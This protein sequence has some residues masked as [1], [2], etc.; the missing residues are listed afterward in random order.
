MM[1]P[2]KVGWR[3][4]A[5]VAV[6]ASF[7]PIAR[8]A[9]GLSSDHRLIMEEIVNGQAIDDALYCGPDD[10]PC[11]QAAQ[12]RFGQEPTASMRRP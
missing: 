11:W 9:P 1:S 7:T 4:A 2:K 5:V 3:C 12:S 10:R 8:S 6:L